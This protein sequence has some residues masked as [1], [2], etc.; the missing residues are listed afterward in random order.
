MLQQSTFNFLNGNCSLDY[1]NGKGVLLSV[2]GSTKIVFGSDDKTSVITA[3]ELIYS[4]NEVSG[5]SLID[6]TGESL[7]TGTESDILRVN[8]AEVKKSFRTA[9]LIKAINKGDNW[10]EESINRVNHKNVVDSNKKD[11]AGGKKDKDLKVRNKHTSEPDQSEKNIDY[12]HEDSEQE[13]R[14]VKQKTGEFLVN[15]V[16]FLLGIIGS[17]SFGDADIVL[18]II[19]AGVVGITGF[20]IIFS[21]LI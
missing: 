17:I 18:K 8:K 6:E 4:D 14:G 5:S 12:E 21:S 1:F 2:N 13:D 10:Y 19:F 15:G 16:D 9:K 3:A 11:E 7:S 20:F